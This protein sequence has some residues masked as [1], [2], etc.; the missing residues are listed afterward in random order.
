MQEQ[1]KKYSLIAVSLAAVFGL[2]YYLCKYTNKVCPYFKQQKDNNSQSQEI[3]LTSSE[4][5]A[6]PVITP[7]TQIQS[8][9]VPQQELQ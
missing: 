5:V 6:T 2:G 8:E 7:I 4:P 9:S 3:Q 1:H